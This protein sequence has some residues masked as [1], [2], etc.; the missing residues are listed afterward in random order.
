[1]VQIVKTLKSEE[2]KK[3]FFWTRGKAYSL[4]HVE[5]SKIKKNKTSIV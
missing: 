5:R 2:V 4:R 1:M 3:Y